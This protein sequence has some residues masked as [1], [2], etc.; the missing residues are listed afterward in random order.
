MLNHA[1]VC[2]S[3]L[4]YDGAGGRKR[5]TLG[6]VERDWNVIA[7][8]AYQRCCREKALSSSEALVEHIINIHGSPEIIS[9]AK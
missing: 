5:H 9:V 1:A 8:S 6:R 4:L 7:N 3:M 2:R